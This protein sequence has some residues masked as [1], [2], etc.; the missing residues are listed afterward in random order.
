M[1][2]PFHRTVLRALDRWDLL[3]AGAR[4]F[5]YVR[6]DS[7]GSLKQIVR[8]AHTP[9]RVTEQDQQEF[10][11]FRPIFLAGGTETA[12][13]RPRR[14]RPRNLQQRIASMHWPETKP[15]YSA[16]LVDSEG[17]TWLEEYR[18]FY[19]DQV[20]DNPA[21]TRW[22]IFNRE[23]VWLGRVEVPGRLLVKRVQDDLVLGVWKDD[24]GAASIRS[25]RLIKPG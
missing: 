25:F 6:F 7:T 1:P 5:E 21:P 19:G 23:G 12:I 15:P 22:S 18:F 4:A 11:S 10:A 2:G 17:N 14:S 9:V 3:Y 20:P 8:Q 13:T 16:L 24:D